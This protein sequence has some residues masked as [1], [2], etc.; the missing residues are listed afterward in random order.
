MPVK[1]DVG[2]N[3]NTKRYSTTMKNTT[4]DTEDINTTRTTAITNL[5]D[6]SALSTLATDGRS[7][8][9]SKVHLRQAKF[10]GFTS[11][12]FLDK[13]KRRKKEK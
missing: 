10:F 9:P 3:A 6:A 13:C 8:K 2:G 4:T 7:K 12:E 11:A 5:T 1:K